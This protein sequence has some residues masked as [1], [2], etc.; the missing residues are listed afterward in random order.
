MTRHVRVRQALHRRV[1][2]LAA[3]HSLLTPSDSTATATATAT[4]NGHLPSSSAQAQAVE[5]AIVAA[6]AAS[7]AT[8]AV[9]DAVPMTLAPGA[10]NTASPEDADALALD[11]ELPLPPTLGAAAPLVSAGTAPAARI[12]PTLLTPAPAG[13]RCGA[14]A[15]RQHSAP[16]GARRAPSAFAQAATEASGGVSN[17]Q[18]QEPPSSP[19]LAQYA[20]A[21][22]VVDEEVAQVWAQV[23]Q[24]A[25][26]A[27]AAPT[28]AAGA[29]GASHL[30]RSTSESGA[31]HAAGPE[32]APRAR[33]QSMLVQRSLGAPRD[34]AAASAAAGGGDVFFVATAHDTVVW[35]A[36]LHALSHA[37][38][39]AVH[40]ARTVLECVGHKQS[41]AGPAS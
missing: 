18:H 19:P 23:V 17:G 8:V 24:Q 13:G 35:L 6:L 21:A 5:G 28:T 2:A 14:I 38:D 7:A 1:L 39:A 16:A 26:A 32:H 36:C 20:A 37:H 34:S 30:L 29:G 31:T 3:A 4:L 41:H 9:D 10:H 15:S 25:S 12:S 11:F 27:A 33:A 40:V 22:R